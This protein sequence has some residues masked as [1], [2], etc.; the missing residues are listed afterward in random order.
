M[1]TDTP[2]ERGELT[3][4][5]NSLFGTLGFKA[6]ASRFGSVTIKPPVGESVKFSNTDIQGIKDFLSTNIVDKNADASLEYMQG[7]IQDV[8]GVEATEE[9]IDTSGY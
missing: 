5:I 3:R 4:D 6:T 1:L 8:D 9:V 7:Y 2:R